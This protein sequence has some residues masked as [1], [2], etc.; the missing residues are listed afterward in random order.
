[1]KNTHM[2][3]SLA[4]LVLSVLLLAGCEGSREVA[5]PGKQAEM[6]LSATIG[7]PN[8][9]ASLSRGEGAID[10]VGGLPPHRLSI[11]VAMMLFNT[12][13]PA[14]V[15]P[16]QT[17]LEAGLVAWRRAYF[18]GVDQSNNVIN[19]DIKFTNADGSAVEKIFYDEMGTH[20]F[21]KCAYPFADAINVMTATGGMVSFRADG[22]Q[23]IMCTGLGWGNKDNPTIQ[24][25]IFKHKLSK[26]NIYLAASSAEAI[27]QYGRI[28]SVEVLN[29]PNI[30]ILNLYQETV[31]AGAALTT[32][33]TPVGFAANQPLP[34]TATDR[35]YVMAL[36]STSFTL[37]IVTEKR[38]TFYADVTFPGA[39]SEAGKSYDVTLN[40]MEA[41]E[42]TIFAEEAEEW[43]MDS[44]FN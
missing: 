10:P 6:R 9:P 22:S 18:G 30:I 24:A 36:P 2:K 42:I 21:L 40:F 32:S 31:S 16:T 23:D 8:A 26:L 43:W 13:D 41:D 7:Q 1:M 17:D 11:G 39:G 5:R 29:Q 44:T 25:L 15:Q 19:G 34:A 12:P 3:S 28:Q 4:P 20:F 27:D 37:K 14:T 38:Q 33:Y 35:G